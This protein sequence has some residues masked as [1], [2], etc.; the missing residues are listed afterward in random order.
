V[1]LTANGFEIKKNEKSG[2]AL[3]P[4]GL[5]RDRPAQRIN[6]AAAW[7]GYRDMQQDNM[8]ASTTRSKTNRQYGQHNMKASCPGG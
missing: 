8:H 4:K 6:S 7:T 5:N 1:A 2:A 3:F